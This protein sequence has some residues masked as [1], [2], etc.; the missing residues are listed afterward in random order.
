MR[1]GPTGSTVLRS[2]VVVV[3]VVEVGEVGRTP[4]VIVTAVLG[5]TVVPPAG[6]WSM[7]RPTFGSPDD[8]VF[9]VTF[10]SRPLAWMAEVAAASD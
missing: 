3:E 5:S 1:S 7:T 6:S 10:T 2:R 8:T 4:T 9:G